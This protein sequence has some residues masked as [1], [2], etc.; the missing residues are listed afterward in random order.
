LLKER[1]SDE[2]LRKTK[3]YLRLQIEDLNNDIFV[4]QQIY[5]TK[6]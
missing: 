4:H 3:V 1:V 6:N 5:T 2:I